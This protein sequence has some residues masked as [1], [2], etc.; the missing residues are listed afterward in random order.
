MPTTHTYPLGSIMSD[1]TS[2]NLR[3]DAAHLA[4]TRR[5]ARECHFEHVAVLALG[6]QTVNVHVYRDAFII[7]RHDGTELARESN[8]LVAAAIAHGADL[9]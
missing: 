6:C 8:P 5:L 9:V 3:A 4:K 2:S 1:Y 7:E